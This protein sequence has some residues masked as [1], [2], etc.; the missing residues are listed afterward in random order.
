MTAH[1]L[2]HRGLFSDV[3]QFITEQLDPMV[4]ARA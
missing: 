4:T 3:E 1:S 2:S